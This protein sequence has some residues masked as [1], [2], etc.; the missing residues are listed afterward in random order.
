M[1]YA[2]TSLIQI[3]SKAS[4][5]TVSKKE[6]PTKREEGRPKGLYIKCN[7]HYQKGNNN[8]K[9]NSEKGRTR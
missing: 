4:K 7:I 3:M 1:S 8:D 5:T 9:K 6:L 2:H